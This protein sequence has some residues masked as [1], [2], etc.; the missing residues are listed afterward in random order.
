MYIN[1]S[2][3]ESCKFSFNC[4]DASPVAASLY[5]PNKYNLL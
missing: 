2:D 5:I 3:E 1:V 4:K